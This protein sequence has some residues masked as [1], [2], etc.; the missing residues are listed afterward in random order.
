MNKLL[1][2]GFDVTKRDSH[3]STTDNARRLLILA[4]HLERYRRNTELDRLRVMASDAEESVE[5][6]EGISAAI[7]KYG[8]C[9][10]M[11]RACDPHGELVAAGICC[12]Y[13]E[14][15]DVPVMDDQAKATIEGLARTTS[16]LHTYISD[17]WDLILDQ[18]LP[19]SAEIDA[20]S[21]EGLFSFLK[22]KRPPAPSPTAHPKEYYYTDPDDLR[23]KLT[24]VGKV[25]EVAFKQYEGYVFTK[26]NFTT[27]T[28]LWK[29][30]ESFVSKYSSSFEKISHVAM[31]DDSPLTTETLT[32]FTQDVLRGLRSFLSSN[33]SLIKSNGY[34][35]EFTGDEFECDISTTFSRNKSTMG[36]AGW[37]SGDIKRVIDVVVSHYFSNT[38]PDLG[39]E[40]THQIADS[41]MY[42][43][44][45]A[46]VK[47]ALRTM[48]NVF[49]TMLEFFG[50][51][52]SS[53]M[54]EYMKFCNTL[55][56]AAV[57]SQAS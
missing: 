31:G 17:T 3:T 36:A 21:L 9:T 10:S 14:L 18:T 13:E 24:T 28:S 40:F 4:E 45:N 15:S 1:L 8:I 7:T 26:R 32:K 42:H 29:V 16:R 30:S 51:Y 47:S 20:G 19:T 54:K 49:D 43:S 50:E 41:K 55:V 48:R 33:S 34:E 44:G 22:R 25:D 46:E 6:L 35:I 53:P 11:M 5:R 57:A 38:V 56:D 2:T 39:F 27:A 12:S 23:D 52:N 37:T